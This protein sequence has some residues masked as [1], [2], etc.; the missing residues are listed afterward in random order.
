MPPTQVCI[1]A[2]PM[3]RTAD[4]AMRIVAVASCWSRRSFGCEQLDGR[5]RNRKGNR[6]FRET[7]FIDAA[8]EYEKALKEVDDP[9][10]H[11]NLGARVLEGLQARRRRRGRRRARRARSSATQIPSTRHVS[12]QVCVKE[13]STAVRRR[14][15]RRT[16]ARRASS[17]RRSSS[18]RSTTAQLA[19]I[20]AQHLQCVA[21]GAPDRRRDPRADDPGLDRLDPVQEGDRLLGGP[22]QR[23][24]PTTPRSWAA[25]PASTSRPTTGASR[26]S[27]T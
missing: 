21:Q 14:A 1:V 24:S 17:A 9:I 18:A 19:D 23:R 15:T 10:I 2:R 22:A 4:R 6:L 8:G 25:S 27:G 3:S 7:R 13:G 16:S 5:N 12:K 11:Y 26:S 20:A